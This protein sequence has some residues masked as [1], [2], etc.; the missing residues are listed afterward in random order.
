MKTEKFITIT[1]DLMPLTTKILHHGRSFRVV[2][3][4][5][6]FCRPVKLLSS[7]PR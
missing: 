5:T 4:F 6:V 7:L 2:S 1:A 3:F